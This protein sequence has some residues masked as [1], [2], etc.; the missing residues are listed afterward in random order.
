MD[1]KRRWTR[2]E[3]LPVAA[4]LCQCLK[5]YCDRLIVA[6]SLRRG[7]STVGD[8]EILYVPKMEE[9]PLDF[10]ETHMVSLVGIEIDRLL[11]DGTLSRRPS[12]NGTFA[13]GEKNK[14]ALHRTG[15]GIDLFRTTDEAWW[16]YLVCRTGPADSNK[17][18]AIAAQ[19]RGYTWNPYGTGF[20]KLADGHQVT[21]TSEA[22]VFEF[23]G[24]PYNEPKDRR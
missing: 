17:R 24:L 1:D 3:A 23:V 4:E 6:G 8:I 14:L 20:T 13:W 21:V 9:Q 16:N 10:F 2:A 12:K 11:D 5:P 18:I 19:E 22:E 15:I 7:A